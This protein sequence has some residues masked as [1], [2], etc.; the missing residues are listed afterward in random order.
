M[1][2]RGTKYSADGSALGMTRTDGI[3]PVRTRDSP[4]HTEIDNHFSFFDKSMHVARRVV[5]RISNK[6]HAGQA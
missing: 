5:L 2:S 3:G 6:E 1:I 4:V